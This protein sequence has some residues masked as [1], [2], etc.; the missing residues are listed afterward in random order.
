[1][2][3][4]ERIKSELNKSLKE[5]SSAIEILDD[6]RR[7]GRHSSLEESEVLKDLS[8]V[9]SPEVVALMLESKAQKRNA[10]LS[11]LDIEDRKYD[12]FILVTKQELSDFNKYLAGM[13]D[14]QKF[15]YDIIFRPSDIHSSALQIHSDGNI[16]RS[17]FIDSLSDINKKERQSIEEAIG[18]DAHNYV[19][20]GILYSDSG[21][22]I[23]SI[24]HLNTMNR[25][26][27]ESHQSD[28]LERGENR[29]E[30]LDPIFLK[31][32][33][34]M[35]RAD[36]Y[37]K[38]LNGEE[39]FINKRL[40]KTFRKHLAEFTATVAVVDEEQNVEFKKR[41]YS[42]L[43]KTEKYLRDAL[44][45]LE[46]THSK[47]ELEEVLSRRSG[48]H[49]LNSV[50]NQ[51]ELTPAQIEQV[52]G[53]YNQDQINLVL[54]YNIPREDVESAKCFSSKEMSKAVF[55]FIDESGLNYQKAFNKVKDFSS[56]YQLYSSTQFGLDTNDL[57]KSQF[58]S[59][60]VLAPETFGHLQEWYTKA[61]EKGAAALFETIKMFEIYKPTEDRALNTISNFGGKDA[62]E[63]LAFCVGGQIS[64]LIKSWLDAG[65]DVNKKT[66]GI[67]PIM[68]AIETG[69]QEI[70][71]QIVRAGARI[72]S[73]ID[74]EQKSKYFP[75]EKLT[76]YLKE[77]ID[78]ENIKVIR[79]VLRFS[80][81][82]LKQNINGVSPLEY[83][84]QSKKMNVLKE[85]FPQG[86]NIEYIPSKMGI[87]NIN[88]NIKY[89]DNTSIKK[90][91]T[92]KIKEQRSKV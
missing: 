9:Y 58:L 79:N 15:H 88:I 44:R 86:R 65:A 8:L 29:L 13:P 19:Q 14:G 78:S 28:Y 24:Q 83:A 40:N 34:S 31:H 72:P 54:H 3:K 39:L 56:P 26:L 89:P 30:N 49:I 45:T 12:P 46:E 48:Q 4:Y 18:A 32:I 66:N 92:V 1:M 51:M 69:N 61:G 60:K 80:P 59:S 27:N 81:D 35:S 25:F 5:V 74:R 64:H 91:K 82:T 23:F 22:S 21:C 17:F 11:A 85:L 77:A 53:L 7:T 68:Q 55:K 33:Q 52:Q 63:F 87:E 6:L 36:Q 43:Y 73:F 50:Y 75:S 57:K 16:A 41:N 90:A 76:S 84:V 10:R 71:D 2:P 70:I 37:E 62:N 47:R 67:S 42:I 38:Y 20:G